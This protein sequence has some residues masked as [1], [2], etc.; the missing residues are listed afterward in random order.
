MMQSYNELK[1]EMEAI[2]HQIFSAKKNESANGLKV[3]KHLCKEFGF[4][5]RIFNGV[6]SKGCCNK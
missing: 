3:L 2:Q 1:T 5:T 6:L 4:N